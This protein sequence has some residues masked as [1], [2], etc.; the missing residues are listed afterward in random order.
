MMATITCGEVA[1]ILAQLPTSET[2]AYEADA[3]GDPPSIFAADTRAMTAA[4]GF[5]AAVSGQF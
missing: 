5:C 3:D 2:D 1:R 4:I